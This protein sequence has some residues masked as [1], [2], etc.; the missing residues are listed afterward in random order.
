MTAVPES[1]PRLPAPAAVQRTARRRVRTSM[2]RREWTGAGGTAASIAGP[3]V[4]RS[5]RRGIP[6]SA[7]VR[8]P[9]TGNAE[10]TAGTNE[11]A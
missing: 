1:T 3:H 7:E 2:T 9:V 10:R 6:P 8:A 4:A 11:P 5:G